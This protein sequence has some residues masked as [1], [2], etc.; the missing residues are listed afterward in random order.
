[1]NCPCNDN[2]RVTAQLLCAVI[3]TDRSVGVG[4]G[5][6]FGVKEKSWEF[7]RNIVRNKSS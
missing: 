5:Q 7:N 1:M 2:L 6:E 4:M 3:V